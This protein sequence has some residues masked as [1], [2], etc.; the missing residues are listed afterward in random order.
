[1]GRSDST[2]DTPV[3]L[4]SAEPAAALQQ[5]DTADDATRARLFESFYPQLKQMARRHMQ[6][7]R[8]PD[9]TLQPT[10]VV[11]EFYLRLAQQRQMTFNGR[12]HFLAFASRKMRRLLIDHAR[13]HGAERHGGAMVKV[14][15]D[16]ADRPSGDLGS[17]MLDLDELLDLD[18]LLELFSAA[19]P[20]GVKVVELKYFGGMA[21]KEIAEVLAIDERTAKRDWESARSWLYGELKKSRSSRGKQGNSGAA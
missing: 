12:A 21:F 17:D 5:W 19:D 15:L 4:D 3:P 20:R 16:S 2:P 18:K 14:Q 1:M 7:E 11:N 10:A 13:S 9:H 8:R 6:R